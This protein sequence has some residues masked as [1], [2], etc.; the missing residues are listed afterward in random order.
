[1]EREIACPTCGRP[2]TLG[3]ERRPR[4]APFCSRRCRLA[5]LGAW[6]DGRYVVSR[7]AGDPEPYDR[8][9]GDAGVGS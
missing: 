3:G 6:A 2:V 5:D 4:E 8:P 7:P 1:M 9:E